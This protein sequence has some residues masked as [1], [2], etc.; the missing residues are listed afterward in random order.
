MNHLAKFKSHRYFNQILII[1]GLALCFLIYKVYIWI[2]T[3]STDNA[4]IE[5]DISHISSEVN[6]VI[7]QVLVEENNRVTKDQVIA[8]IKDDDYQALVDKAESMLE[9]AQRNIQSIEQ[10]IKLAGID[11][12]KALEAFD[13]AQINFDLTQA[14]YDRTKMLSKDNYASQQKLDNTEIAFKKA[15]N[16]LSQAKLNMQTAET[17]LELMEIERLAA[18][19]KYETAKQ[20][21]FLAHRNLNNTIIRSP[22]NG[23]IGNSSIKMGNYIRAGV[24]L[25]SVVPEKLYL[26]ANFK[27]TQVAN[28][29]PGMKATMTFDSENGRTI[30]GQI[31][32]ISPAT[33]SKFSLLPPANATGNFTKIV[34]RLPVTIDFEIPAELVGRLAPGMSAIVSIRTDKGV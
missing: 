30:T 11:K 16:E 12:V 25:F 19:A 17:K 29:K 21:A 23:I 14:D 5:A 6:G 24:I 20:E 9:G 27:E 18:I 13:F 2:N 34:Q 31:R 22:I 33:G 7:H 28:F 26:K 10:N 15:K 1:A 3:E 32:N 8:K 4:Y